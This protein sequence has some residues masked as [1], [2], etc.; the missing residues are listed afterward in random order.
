MSMTM[1]AVLPV[2]IAFQIWKYYVFRQRVS[3]AKIDFRSH[4]NI[5]MQMNDELR[6]LIK[7]ACCLANTLNCIIQAFRGKDGNIIN[8]LEQKHR[9]LLFGNISRKMAR[10]RDAND[11]KD[12]EE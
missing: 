4:A 5:L 1:L 9:D 7:Y 10:D 12:S 6:K 3:T 2:L 11:S 8:R